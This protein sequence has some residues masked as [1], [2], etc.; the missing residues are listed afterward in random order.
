MERQEG[1]EGV[2]EGTSGDVRSSKSEGMK[3]GAL[4]VARRSGR[5]SRGGLVWNRWN[6]RRSGGSSGWNDR[7]SMGIGWSEKEWEK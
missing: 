7:G 4:G 1:M 6:G 5:G 2:I 3:E